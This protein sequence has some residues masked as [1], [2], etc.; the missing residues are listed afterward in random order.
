MFWVLVQQWLESSER[1]DELLF[2]Q[3]C[4]TVHRN[5]QAGAVVPYGDDS[6]SGRVQGT[7]LLCVCV[8]AFVIMYISVVYLCTCQ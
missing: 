6:D 7:L 4:V 3:E 5:R 2:F 8:L 1:D